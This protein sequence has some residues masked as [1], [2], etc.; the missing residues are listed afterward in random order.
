MNEGPFNFQDLSLSK[1]GQDR[2]LAIFG[3]AR[4]AML[5]RRRRRIVGHSAAAAMV[6]CVGLTLGYQLSE[7]TIPPNSA[8]IAQ[9]RDPV[10]KLDSLAEPP[11]F[12]FEDGSNQTTEALLTNNDRPAT[13]RFSRG[14]KSSLVQEIS[15]QEMLT[16]LRQAGVEVGRIQ[17]GD[18]VHYVLRS[19]KE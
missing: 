12:A 7:V 5:W 4:S 2:A 17:I 1:A 3:A 14:S 16:E 6:G 10:V 8:A 9:F 18:E 15:T 11:T 19:N 13:Q